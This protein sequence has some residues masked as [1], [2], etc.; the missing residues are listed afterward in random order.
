MIKYNMR[1]MRT[2]WYVE[3]WLWTQ[4][5][6][7]AQ[8]QTAGKILIHCVTS[9]NLCVRE[10]KGSGIMMLVFH[11]ILRFNGYHYLKLALIFIY[12]VLA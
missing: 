7:G 1:N 8:L 2:S 11:I 4:T 12:F 5:H 9:Q 6:A 10:K 3:Y